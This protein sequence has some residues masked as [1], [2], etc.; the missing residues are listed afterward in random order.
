MGESLTDFYDK[1]KT[2]LSKDRP[3]VNA[4]LMSVGSPNGLQLSPG[5]TAWRNQ[6]V[7]ER[8]KLK[9]GCCKRILLDIYC[10]ILPL[11]QEYIDG[12]QGQMKSDIDSFLTNKNMTAAQYL[13]SGYEK[14]N[15]PLLEFLIRS[16]DMIGSQFMKEADE[17]LKDAQKNDIKIPPPESDINNKEIQNQLVDMDKDMEYKRFMELLKQKTI[18]KIVADVSKV[19]ED[20]QE[21]KEMTFDP[22]PDAVTESTVS[23]GIDYINQKLWKENVEMTESMQEE[24]IGLAIRESTLNQLDVVFNQPYS[25]LKDFSSRMRF[26]KGV[27]INESAI[28]YLKEAATEEISKRYEPL[29]KETDGNKYDVSNYEKVSSDGKKTPMTDA[30]ARKVLDDNGYKSY[31]NKGKMKAESVRLFEE[32]MQKAHPG[33]YQSLSPEERQIANKRFGEIECSI[34]KDKKGFFA[35]TH[36]AR[37]KSYPTLEQ[38]PKKEVDFVSTTS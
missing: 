31:Q 32:K 9:E 13:T 2:D 28:T 26:G 29:Y 30:E 17:T 34:M 24:M 1:L 4:N 12:N 7:K 15:A 21:E 14:T 18:N 33:D 27:L 38:L 16:T 36:R 19:I 3:N 10:K 6:A 20:K 5:A 8:D 22:K 35:H 23:V 25:E 37:T 11:D